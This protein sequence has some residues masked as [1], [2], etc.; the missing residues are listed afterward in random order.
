MH[1]NDI[2][3]G[4]NIHIALAVVAKFMTNTYFGLPQI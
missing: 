4:E 3:Q 2:L 1:L